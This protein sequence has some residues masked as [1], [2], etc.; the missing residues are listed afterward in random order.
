MSDQQSTVSRRTFL[1]G[2]AIA[3][4]SG[5][6]G[7]GGLLSACSGGRSNESK[8]T[9]LRPAGEVYIPELPDKAIDGKPIRAAVIGCGGRGSG[10]AFNF[11]DAADGVSIVACSDPFKDRVDNF[12]KRLKEGKNI[13]LPDNRCFVG[14][15]TYKNVCELPEVDLVMIASPGLFHP[16]HLKY[17]IDQGKHVFCE[18][19]AAVDAAGY[20]KF[21]TAVRQ[22]QTNNLCLLTGT[23]EHYRRSN[24][25]S[26]RK[27]QEGYIGQIT[28]GNV[29][30]AQGHSH[31]ITRQ[32]EWTEMEYM[33][34]DHFSWRW[35]SGD[36]LVDQLIHY[37]DIFTWFSHL[38]PVWVFGTGA[39]VRK[40]TGNIYDVF[41]ID[42]EYE[43]GIHMHGIERQINNCDNRV[44][45]I[46]QGTKGRWNGLNRSPVNITD[47]DGNVIW[48][49]DEVAAKEQFKQHD[50]Y[51]LEHVDLINHI[52][53]GKVIN[54]AETTATSTMACIM[55][56]ESACTGKFYTWDE[57]IQSDQNFMPDNMALDKVDMEK[58]RLIPL[59]GTV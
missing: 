38:K 31:Y 20:R 12:R 43:G 24:V 56:L 33:L 17:A 9:P 58:Y 1:S 10:A 36:I 37:V 46:I 40:Y 6:L 34:R 2:A 21:M 22:A 4:A 47:L 16:D 49:Y 50:P 5:A 59:P 3:G 32:P 13:E 57:M 7:V 29:Y 19:P 44:G 23:M 54:F 39:R 42:F 8:Y 26:Y 48:E 51:T 27:I 55:A 11:L 53:K 45:V 30:C 28:S 18:K 15:D 25:E 41:S 35:L 14:I 52:R